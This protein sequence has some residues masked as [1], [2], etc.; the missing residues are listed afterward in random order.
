MKT[1]KQNT[2]EFMKIKNKLL[3][4]A[5]YALPDEPNVLYLISR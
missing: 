4:P 1:F 2:L 3:T 5:V